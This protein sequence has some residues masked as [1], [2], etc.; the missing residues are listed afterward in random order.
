MGP[1][2]KRAREKAEEAEVRKRMALPQQ[3]EP[4][5]VVLY[6]DGWRGIVHDAFEALDSYWLAD[7]ESGEVIRDESGEIIAFKS[8]EL[9]VVAP[10]P[11]LQGKNPYAPA[12]GVFV[13]GTA[14]Q[15]MRVLE[16][17]GPPDPTKRTE[18]QELLAIPCHLCDPGSLLRTAREGVN[19]ATLKLAQDQRPDLHVALRAY[20]L[21]HAVEQC[22][23]L[24]RLEDYFCLAGVTVP[25]SEEE[26]QAGVD[27]DEKKW[28]RSVANQLDVCV[29]AYGRREGEETTL[30]DAAQKSLGQACGMCL[31]EVLWQEAAQSCIRKSLGVPELPLHFVDSMNAKIYVVVLPE[32]ASLTEEGGILAFHEA[33]GS[34]YANLG[35]EA[36]AEGDDADDTGKAGTSATGPPATDAP[37]DRSEGP[38]DKTVSQWEAEQDKFADQ[39]KLPPGWIRITSRNTGKTYF[40]NKETQ[41][42][43]F[44]FPLPEG[45]VK[46]VSKSTG[47]TYYFHARR[48]FSTFVRPTE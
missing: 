27:K 29:T 47:K 23:A 20:H 36:D 6:W 22:S 16:H 39:P 14:S 4:G 7:E 40:Y 17:F 33:F 8:A 10:P 12:V 3:L 48:K 25:Y 26:I 42:S 32:D 35:L 24:L 2:S 5:A 31:S 41:E 43:S 13:L 19:P 9:Q 38:Q 37:K 44:E 34:D 30:F 18:P 46:Q 11:K 1:A 15:M 45:W 28:R 21:R